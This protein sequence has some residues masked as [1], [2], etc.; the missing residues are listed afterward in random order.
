[1]IRRFGY[2]LWTSSRSWSTFDKLIQ[3]PVW[4][5]HDAVEEGRRKQ[6]KIPWE[7][8]EDKSTLE[9]LH[10]L[11]GHTRFHRMDVEDKDKE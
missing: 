2:G 3:A 1:L 9:G 7:A 5:S 6:E 11:C 4:C 10:G 8:E